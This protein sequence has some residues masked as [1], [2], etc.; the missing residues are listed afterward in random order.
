VLVE[1]SPQELVDRHA[2]RDVVEVD[3]A[4]A[5]MLDWAKANGL[6]YDKAGAKLIL[7][8]PEEALARSRPIS[9]PCSVPGAAPSA[10]EPGGRV[11]APDRQG[12]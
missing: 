4:G 1:G 7:Y 8:I 6:S 10:G 11:S 2:G 9:A 12:A 5:D 3:D